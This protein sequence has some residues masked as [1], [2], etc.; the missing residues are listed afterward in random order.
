MSADGAA[1]VHDAKKKAKSQAAQT[2]GASPTSLLSTA[3]KSVDGGLLVQ[4]TDL[5]NALLRFYFAAYV[6]QNVIDS[7]EFKSKT[8]PL[9]RDAKN[10]Q[11]VISYDISPIVKKLEAK[12]RGINQETAVAPD[13]PHDHDAPPSS[14]VSSD[15][16]PNQKFGGSIQ[17]RMK[18]LQK[19]GMDTSTTESPSTLT[20]NVSKRYSSQHRPVQSSNADQTSIDSPSPSVST[21]VTT[22][23]SHIN[24]TSPSTVATSVL[25]GSSRHSHKSS[26]SLSSPNLSPSHSPAVANAPSL[27]SISEDLASLDLTNSNHSPKQV[28]GIADSEMPATITLTYTTPSPSIQPNGIPPSPRHH[29]IQSLA[30]PRSRPTSMPP[31]S[32]PS[33]ILQPKI[34]RT[35]SNQPPTPSALSTSFPPTSPETMTPSISAFQ[36]HFPTIEVLDSQYQLEEVAPTQ[37]IPIFPSVPT[38]KPGTGGP[39]SS[40]KDTS[41]PGAIINGRPHSSSLNG[42]PS[43][44][45]TALGRPSSSSVSTTSKHISSNSISGSASFMASNGTGGSSS[46]G[47]HRPSSGA[48]VGSTTSQPTSTKTSSARTPLPSTPSYAV[49]P[50]PKPTPSYAVA[51]PSKPDIPHT[52]AMDPSMVLRLLDTKT[53]GGI[54]VLLLDVR[55]KDDYDR[56]RIAG[57]SVCL[58]P[59]V[60]MRNGIDSQQLEASLVIDPRGEKLFKERHYFD[61]L[62]M[63]DQGSTCLESSG[64]NTDYQQHPSYQ[65]LSGK[66]YPNGASKAVASQPLKI[67]NDVIYTKEFHKIL[68]RPPVLLIGGLEAWKLQLGGVWLD[69]TAINGSKQVNGVT[70]KKHH[71]E[72]ASYDTPREGDRE[73]TPPQNERVRTLHRKS[74]II[75]RSSSS[76]NISAYTRQIPDESNGMYSSGISSISYPIASPPTSSVTSPVPAPTPTRPLP[77]PPASLPQPPP[78]VASV[79]QASHS[80]SPISRIRSNYAEQSHHAYTG[81]TTSPMRAAIDYPSLSAQNL[82]KYP[83]PAATTSLERADPRARHGA[84]NASTTI[85]VSGG[86]GQQIEQGR[87]ITVG[88]KTF[89]MPPVIQSY[90]PVEYWTSAQQVRLTGLKNLGN[91][92]YMNSIIQCLSATVP[93]ARFFIDGRWVRAVNQTNPMGKMGKVARAFATI[94]H[95]MWQGDQTYL[96]PYP[97]RRSIC[98]YAP[99][100]GGSDQHD[101][102]EFLSFLLDGLHEDLNRPLKRIPAPEASPEREAEL[103]SL[104]VQVAGA[105]EWRLYQLRDDSIIVDYF[106]GQFRSRLQCLT[107]NTTSTTYNPFM[108][109]SLPIPTRRGVT[110]LT[111]HDCLDAFVKKEVLEASDAWHCPKCKELR[112]ATK[113]LTLSRLPPVLLIHLKRFSF[114]G[115]FTDKLETTVDFPLKGL[116]LTEYMPPPLPPGA[117][118]SLVLPTN[119]GGSSRLDDPR[120]QLPPYKYDLYAVTNHYGTLTSGHYTSFISTMGQW[121]YCDD[122]RISGAP[123]QNVVGRPAYIL[124]YRRVPT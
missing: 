98:E 106:Q 103:E 109:I 18:A 12:L 38:N 51:P 117:D 10:F 94:V 49:A 59:S 44:N 48:S 107:C 47:T 60:L 81:S 14:P 93:F 27:G 58:E 115:P 52:Q 113:E 99:Q 36:S 24:P 120:T 29:D 3:K 68:Q 87:R 2:K 33:P 23:S 78:P 42:L 8:A 83:E 35:S 15:D 76:G 104:P 61:L 21:T 4:D 53:N 79:T 84:L 30:T 37:I 57:R 89:D 92:C 101:S 19:A 69:G 40:W 45:G 71:R 119:G 26:G 34:I 97:F 66:S 50:P 65:K 112:K 7:Q 123:P 1:L 124:F 20:T 105:Q 25:P 82:V 70:A 88:G 111:L 121:A 90:Y 73:P 110:R 6:M 62:V 46:S 17:E 75:P 9:Y 86:S 16:G 95:E 32:T 122:S 114:K 102:Q 28:N 64:H 56:E 116:D 108:Y 13:P 96:T 74:T 100:F 118:K 54:R 31:S 55:T 85:T 91:T 39:P 77:I 63:Y 72:G 43:A 22:S 80:S 41:S 11:H 67:L 5:H